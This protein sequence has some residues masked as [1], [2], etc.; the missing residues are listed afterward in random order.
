M[1]GY[2]LGISVLILQD[3]LP[4]LSHP[5]ARWDLVLVAFG[6]SLRSCALPL[7][8]AAL[9][10]RPGVR[11]GHFERIP[12]EDC[13]QLMSRSAVVCRNRCPRH[14]QAVGRAMF[15]AR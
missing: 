10:R 7:R 9:D 14:S 4:I 1:M 3:F 6:P 5:A 11:F 15:E 12:T 13:H 2:Y 8:R